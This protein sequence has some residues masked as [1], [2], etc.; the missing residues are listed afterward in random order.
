MAEDKGFLS[1][2]PAPHGG[3]GG[4]VEYRIFVPQGS[5]APYIDHYSQHRGEEETLLPPGS[6]HRV[7][8]ILEEDGK[9]VA[10]LELTGFSK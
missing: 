1:T 5:P 2:S 9:L 8:D 7:I 10:Y 3:F 4:Q 6:Q